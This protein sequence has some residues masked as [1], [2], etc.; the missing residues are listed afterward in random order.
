MTLSLDVS[1][2]L[3]LPPCQARC[4]SVGRVEVHV[5]LSGPRTWLTP[6]LP[7]LLCVTSQVM[8]LLD[9]DGLDWF[10]PIGW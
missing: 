4:I 3:I 6:D 1:G 8:L 5:A 10:D 7:G 2:L 9:S